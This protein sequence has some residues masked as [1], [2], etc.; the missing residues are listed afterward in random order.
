[1][2][3]DKLKVTINYKSKT[4]KERIIN[5]TQAVKKLIKSEIARAG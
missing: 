4:E 1:M 2:A 5:V 3:A